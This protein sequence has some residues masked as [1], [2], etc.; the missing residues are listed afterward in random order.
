MRILIVEAEPKTAT[1]RYKALLQN[2]FVVDRVNRG[3]VG[4]H[5][6]GMATV[7]PNQKPLPE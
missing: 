4:L 7:P 5:P 3:D 2:N 1:C 6:A